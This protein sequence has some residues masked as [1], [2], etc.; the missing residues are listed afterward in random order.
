MKY[1]SDEFCSI[2]YKPFTEAAWDNRHTDP[3]DNLSDCHA[4]CCPQ[5]NGNSATIRANLITQPKEAPAGQMTLLE[6]T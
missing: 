1:I 2:C 3:R 5:C 4:H 6:V